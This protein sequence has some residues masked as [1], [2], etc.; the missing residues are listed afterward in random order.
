MF[1]LPMRRASQK[2]IESAVVEH[3]SCAPFPRQYN[4]DYQLQ[5]QACQLVLEY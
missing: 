1:S 3:G 5:I 2:I 4:S